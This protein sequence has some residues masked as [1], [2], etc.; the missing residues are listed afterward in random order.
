[1]MFSRTIQDQWIGASILFGLILF[2]MLLCPLC[3]SCA[4]RMSLILSLWE[5]GELLSHGLPR[6]LNSID[7]QLFPH[8]L[9]LSSLQCL[10][11]IYYL[12]PMQII[13]ECSLWHWITKFSFDVVDIVY[14]C[15]RDMYSFDVCALASEHDDSWRWMPCCEL[16]ECYASASRVSWNESC[17]YS[18]SE[19]WLISTSVCPVP[20]LIISFILYYWQ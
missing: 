6:C 5:H 10:E 2:V 11:M 8:H 3:M 20:P 19:C 7:F 17:R 15:Y 14:V 16:S 18:H 9:V 13:I 4:R 12:F 1:M